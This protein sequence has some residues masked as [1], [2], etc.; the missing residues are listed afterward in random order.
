MSKIRIDTIALGADAL[1]DYIEDHCCSLVTINDRKEITHIAVF[2]GVNL[3]QGAAKGISMQNGVDAA[4]ITWDTCG[5]P[6]DIFVVSKNEVRE[7]IT[8]L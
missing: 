5:W 2:K 8:N 7:V 4:V 1:A 6:M 3:A